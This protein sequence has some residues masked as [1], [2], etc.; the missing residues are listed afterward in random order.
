VDLGVDS[1]AALPPDFALPPFPDIVFQRGLGCECV[2]R[3][4]LGAA[5]R[6]RI[7][8][9]RKCVLPPLYPGSRVDEIRFTDQQRRDASDACAKHNHT[10]LRAYNL[11]RHS[12]L[13]STYRQSLARFL[14]FSSNN[15]IFAM[16]A[17]PPSTASKAPA[18]APISAKAS[19]KA[20]KTSGAGVAE[21]EKKKRR[22]ARKETYSSYIYKGTCL[23]L[24]ICIF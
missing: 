14:T 19:K 6:G 16:V 13:H 12:T 23:I 3:V 9:H 17:A 5:T 21:G 20:A 11:A 8:A 15:N 24:S 18:K 7:C 10:C 22:K 2:G 1:P 4:V